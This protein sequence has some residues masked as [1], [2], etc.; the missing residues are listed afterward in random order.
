[1]STHNMSTHNMSTHNVS[2]YNIS[3]YNMS[4][5]NISTRFTAHELVAYNE[6]LNL[7]FYCLCSY[8]IG[9]GEELINQHFFRNYRGITNAERQVLKLVFRGVVTIDSTGTN[10]LATV[11]QKAAIYTVKD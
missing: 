2:T 5:H 10:K 8:A 4:T 6:N 7:L 11:E 3:T 9:L 1:M